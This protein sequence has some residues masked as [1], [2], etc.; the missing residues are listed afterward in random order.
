MTKK[1][2]T[3]LECIVKASEEMINLRIDAITIGKGMGYHEHGVR[4]IWDLQSTVW[5]SKHGKYEVQDLTQHINC[6]D[7]AG[8]LLNK[9]RVVYKK[10]LEYMQMESRQHE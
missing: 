3:N 4:T 8:H 2:S 1:D 9:Y 7:F 5:N 10:T 6:I